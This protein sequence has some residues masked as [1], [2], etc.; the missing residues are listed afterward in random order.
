[1][2]RSLEG[3]I[4]DS[5]SVSV[6]IERI[7]SRSQR[8]QTIKRSRFLH[9]RQDI[10]LL[11]RVP[12]NRNN[13]NNNNNGGQT[14]AT[15]VPKDGGGGGG[16]DSQDSA[17][18]DDDDD[19]DDRQMPSNGNNTTTMSSLSGSASAESSSTTSS[20][21]SSTDQQ[22]PNSSSND[23]RSSK[24]RKTHKRMKRSA[25]SS[26]EGNDG[27]AAGAA[28]AAAQMSSKKLSTR[29]ERHHQEGR[30]GSSNSEDSSGDSYCSIRNRDESNHKDDPHSKSHD[31]SKSTGLE[32]D[33]VYS[34]DGDAEGDANKKRQSDEP[35]NTNTNQ[36][37]KQQQ[38]PSFCSS[39]SSPPPP[40]LTAASLMQLPKLAKSGGIVHNIGPMLHD[41]SGAGAGTKIH[42]VVGHASVLPMNGMHPTSRMGPTPLPALS[43]QNL[44]Q[45]Q[46]QLPSGSLHYIGSASH[47][48]RQHRSVVPAVI[49]NSDPHHAGLKSDGSGQYH[50]ELGASYS[51]NEDDMILMDDTLMC[52][53]VFRSRNAVQCGAL[54]DCVMPGMLR[55]Q[56]SNKTNKMISVE[57][58]YDAMGF[59]QQLD[60]AN[61]GEMTAQI[62]PASLEMAL[63]HTPNEARVVTEAK[64]P[65]CVV[66]VTEQ[67]SE[68]MHYSQLEVEGKELLSLL[69]GEHTVADAGDRKGKPTHNLEDVA[70]G[71]CACSTNVHYDK[72]GRAFVDF[73]CSYPLTK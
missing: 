49:L 21:C 46:Q 71:I 16:D 53:F 43:Q 68:L 51:I 23:R 22:L 3:I 38:K 44:M 66:H 12:K 73:M 63:M 28:N 8:W 39:S 40:L 47:D 65:Y 60:R 42:H 30:P 9:G 5:A 45:Q 13:N 70:N 52:P 48:H 25:S 6:M 34:G 10:L 62:I 67:W 33:V 72:E 2:I 69:E 50:D 31:P 1:M 7:G 17:D 55:A 59:M 26:E 15:T 19:D 27:E 58:I 37:D 20:N 24:H 36:L 64:A 54:A 11:P 41:L 18:E 57:M 14:T 35:S 32:Q 4:A 29:S 56:F 61:G